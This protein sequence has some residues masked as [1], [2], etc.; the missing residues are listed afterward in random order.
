MKKDS[1]AL[2]SLLV[3]GIILAIIW[4]VY[5]SDCFLVEIREFLKAPP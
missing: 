4:K 2:L 3:S 1:V 5:C